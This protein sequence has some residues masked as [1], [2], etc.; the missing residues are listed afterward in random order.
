MRKPLLSQIDP[1]LEPYF[2]FLPT[3]HRQV[4]E[5]ATGVI[6]IGIIRVIIQTELT[7][8]MENIKIRS[9]CSHCSIT[10]SA[11][12][13]STS[14]RSLKTELFDVAFGK[15]EHSASLCHYV[16]LNL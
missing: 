9:H 13:L 11:E 10:R 14:K 16:P 8:L 12:L 6:I 2:Y 1:S 5:C 15:R 7:N 3:K 4:I